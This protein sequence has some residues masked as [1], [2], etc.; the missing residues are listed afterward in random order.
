[1][2]TAHNRK[3]AQGSWR[4][5]APELRPALARKEGLPIKP[6]YLTRAFTLRADDRFELTI[7]SFV[8]PY[9]QMPIAQMS[10]KGYVEWVGDHPIAEGAQKVNFYA[11]EEYVV[12]PL[13]DV[14]VNTLNDYTI[15]FDVWRVNE[16]QSIL[17]KEFP[18]FG[19]SEGEV[20]M[21]F[22]LIYV[23]NDLM[24]W[25]ARNVDGRAFNSEDNRPFNLQ[26]PMQRV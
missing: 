24:F 25:G 3:K 13:L 12:T 17:G 6:L 11:D 1:M 20:F 26:I 23:L 5:I 15:G 18:P 19:L 2:D 21:E 8:G 7:T 9:G 10:L 16:G 14:F 4:S 22:D